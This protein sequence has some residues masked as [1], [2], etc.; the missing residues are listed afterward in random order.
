MLSQSWSVHDMLDR[1]RSEPSSST[2]DSTPRLAS[3]S[4]GYR[5]RC[6]VAFTLTRTRTV[7]TLA[8]CHP[9]AGHAHSRTHSLALSFIRS[10]TFLSQTHMVA[11]RHTSRKVFRILLSPVPLIWK[12]CWCCC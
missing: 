4:P 11:N 5:P 9:D 6:S 1:E 10:P 7:L 8:A 2:D 12:A 3:P